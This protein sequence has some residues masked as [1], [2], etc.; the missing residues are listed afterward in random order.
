LTLPKSGVFAAAGVSALPF[1][2]ALAL[3][4]KYLLTWAHPGGGIPAV[5]EG[6]ELSKEKLGMVGLILCLSVAGGLAAAPGEWPIE[7]REIQALADRAPEFEAAMVAFYERERET[8]NQARD[9]MA[10][11][12]ATGNKALY[13]EHLAI[14][15][16]HV[17]LL[18]QGFERALEKYPENPRLMVC[19]GEILYDYAG[20]LEGGV[21]YWNQALEK[22]PKCAAAHNNLAMHCCHIGEYEKGFQHL[23]EALAIEPKNANYLFNAAQVYLVHFPQVAAYKKWDRER[24]FSQAMTYSREATQLKPKDYELA[25]DYAV[26]FLAGENFGVAVVWPDAAKAWQR[27]R[28]NAQR[29]DQRFYSWLNEGRA[30]L[31]AKK[32]VKAEKCVTEALK[33]LPDS[34]PAKALLEE[35][36]TERKKKTKPRGKAE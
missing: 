27:A 16:K 30:W 36:Q 33:I 12:K 19:Y 7:L 10:E 3:A 35:I 22:D 32:W 1:V 13:D 20:D 25:S 29:D 28:N 31:R 23:D 2:H 15:Q 9:K 21:R 6:S 4:E 5:P 8:V 14:A 11:A 18:K 34:G 24:I 17:D 26:N